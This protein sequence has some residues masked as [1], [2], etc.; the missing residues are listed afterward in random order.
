MNIALVIYRAQIARGGA[1]R[2]VHDLSLALKERGH[3]VTV[4]ASCGEA[5]QGVAFVQ[6]GANGVTRNSR[7]RRFCAN[8]ESHL[9]GNRYDIVHACLPI[10]SCDVYHAHSGIESL[11]LRDGHLRQATMPRQAIAKV[12][13]RLNRKRN[14]FAQVEAEL[15]HSASSPLVLCLSNRERDEAIQ[16]FPAAKARILTLYSYPDDARFT[17][18]DVV[19]LRRKV[20]KQLSLDDAQTM[21]L[22][23]GNNFVRKGLAIAIRAIGAMKDPRCMLYVAGEGDTHHYSEIALHCGAVGRVMF[24]G[25]TD[26]VRDLLAA[27][28]ALVLPTRAEP[29]G[30]VVVEAML[31]GVP[32]IVSEVAGASEI[33]ESGRNGFVIADPT[34][35]KTWAETMTK[36][37]DRAF[38]EKLADVCLEQRDRFSYDH[39]IDSIEAIYQSRKSRKN[40]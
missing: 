25:K 2:Y 16:M 6:I 19:A 9:Q 4:L 28:D 18:D 26:S 39:H 34:D 40:A 3:R 1:E 35:V 36:L 38:R 22:F 37:T 15:I 27:A 13:N 24:L 17:L 30:M 23:I 21:F 5:A 11:T 10:P 32:P 7:Y 8:I 14:A 20:R 31:M 29:F 12:F 33:I